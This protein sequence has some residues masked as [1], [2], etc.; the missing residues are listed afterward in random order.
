M[1]S[2]QVITAIA[3]LATIIA[4][5]TAI[6]LER[7]DPLRGIFWILVTMYIVSLTPGGRP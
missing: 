1:N 4:F 7:R 2:N 3:H 6:C 5:L